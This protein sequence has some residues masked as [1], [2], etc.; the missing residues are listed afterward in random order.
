MPTLT[1]TLTP[2]TMQKERRL[3]SKSQLLDAHGIHTS[4]VFLESWSDMSVVSNWTTPAVQE[5]ADGTILFTPRSMRVDYPYA[6]SFLGQPMVVIK[7]A[8]GG[9]SAYHFPRAGS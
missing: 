1:P 8:D 9:L 5:K 3:E 2:I 7:S 4:N 6:F